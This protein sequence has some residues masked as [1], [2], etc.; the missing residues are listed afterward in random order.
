MRFGQAYVRRTRKHACYESFHSAAP[1]G[2]QI[3]VRTAMNPDPDWPAR[4][5]YLLSPMEKYCVH[6]PEELARVVRELPKDELGELMK[7][8]YRLLADRGAD[9]RCLVEH[10]AHLPPSRVKRID[11][12]LRAIL[13]VRGGSTELQSG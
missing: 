9:L 6:P 5:D 7:I 12:F 13:P 2:L 11:A 4:L 8:T 1:K 10:M 3:R